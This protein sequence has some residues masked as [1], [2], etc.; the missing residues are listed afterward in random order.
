MSFGVLALI[1]LAGLAGP[2]LSAARRPLV[3]VVVGE[4][5][6]GVIIGRSGFRWLDTGDPTVSFLA[7]VGFAMLMLAA[8]MHV[9][10]LAVGLAPITFTSCFAIARVWGYIAHFAECRVHNRILRPAAAYV[11]AG[12]RSV[13]TAQPESRQA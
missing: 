5:A 13:R 8:G 11:G 3:P 12:L 2:L 7:D 9:V 4:I 10:F 6:I 1:V